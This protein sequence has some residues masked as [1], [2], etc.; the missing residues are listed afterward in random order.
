[1]VSEVEPVSGAQYQATITPGSP[2]PKLEQL[3]EN[4]WVLPQPFGSALANVSLQYTLCYFIRDA[5]GQ[6]SLIDPGTDDDA[7]FTRIVEELR[8]LGSGLDDIAAVFVTH[9]HGDHLG[10]A[11]KVR[12][13]TGALVWLSEEDCTDASSSHLARSGA[14]LASRCDEWEVPEVVRDEFARMPLR[15]PSDT[16]CVTNVIRDGDVLDIPGHHVEAVRTP[17]HTRGHTIFVHRSDRIAYTGDHLHSTLGTAL[18]SPIGA[19]A[20][21]MER[22]RES[23]RRA[24]LL[25]GFDGAPAHEFVYRNVDMRA[26][27]LWLKSARRSREVAAVLETNPVASPWEIATQLRWNGGLANRRGIRL[28]AALQSVAI[29]RDDV[30]MNGPMAETVVPAK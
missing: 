8:E 10:L 22:Y 14:R 7:N 26:R 25:T 1:M 20:E 16:S 15:P 28:F 4:V 17:G 27:Q 21:T 18:E 13:A 12:A 23:L 2:T 5:D 29:H 6:F 19:G 9:H 11:A 30:A 3:R 24:S